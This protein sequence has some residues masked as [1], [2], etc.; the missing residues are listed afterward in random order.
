MPTA[1]AVP[2]ALTEK[3]STATPLFITRRARLGDLDTV[4]AL[5]RR[6]SLDTRFARYATARRELKI[7]EWSRLVHPAAGSTWL[8]V[9]PHAPDTAV[10]LTHLLKT[11]TAHTYELAVLI[12]DRWQ[13]Q[14]LGSRLTAQALAEATA[15]GC[16]TLTVSFGASNR[17]AT[18]IMRRLGIPIPGPADGVIDISVRLPERS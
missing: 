14:G 2:R 6:C 9:L 4:N 1:G 13:S 12:E 10:A 17:R 18:A 5:H 16:R 7:S 15:Q 8:T 11:R 3:A